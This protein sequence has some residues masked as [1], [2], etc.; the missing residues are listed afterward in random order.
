MVF[1]AIMLLQMVLSEH[2]THHNKQMQNLLAI[3]YQLLER[4]LNEA[5]IL[6]PF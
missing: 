4:R 6:P 5:P 3:V 2:H 1:R